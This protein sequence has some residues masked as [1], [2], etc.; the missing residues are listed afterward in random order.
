MAAFDTVW[1]NALFVKLGELGIKGKLLRLARDSYVNLKCKI[2][3]Q[4]RTSQAV[5][6]LCG[7]RQGGVLSAFY[8]LVF[9][10]QLLVELE[11]S[12]HGAQLCNVPCGNPTLADDIALIGI[13]PKSMQSMLDIVYRY[14]KMWDFEINVS[15][16][17]ILIISRSRS[18]QTSEFKIGGAVIPR[19]K[20]ATHLGIHIQENLTLKARIEQRCQK[21]RNAFYAMSELGLHPSA[22]NPIKSANLYKKIIQPSILY[23]SELWNGLTN[24]DTVSLSR[25]QHDIVKKIQ[26]LPIR[27]RSDICEPMVGISRISSEVEKRKLMFLHSLLRLPINA[28][29]LQIF[30]RR[31]V[32]HILHPDIK[33]LGFIPDVCTL[34]KKYSGEHVLNAYVADYRSL[35]TKFS[36]KN[37]VKLRI[38]SMEEVTWRQRL[39]DDPDFDL[40]KK[41]KDDLHPSILWKLSVSRSDVFIAHTVAKAWIRTPEVSENYKCR[42]NLDDTSTDTLWHVISS[43]KNLENERRHFL[44]NVENYCS[45]DIKLCLERANPEDS[46]SLVISGKSSNDQIRSSYMKQANN[47]LYLCVKATE[48]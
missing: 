45:S 1:Q 9:I 25:I 14:T 19:V 29:P 40:F 34:L 33:M 26:G 12:G 47:F 37:T 2:R 16:S 27:T 23:G 35:P 41:I 17:N 42:C 21:G 22:L 24:S 30:I 44:S 38:Q 4:E 48:S 20:V 8:Y 36:W 18:L 7:V 5:S 3:M 46:V 6:V 43:C 13:S 31:Y 39:Q 32:H 15:K 28:L 11:N 10:D